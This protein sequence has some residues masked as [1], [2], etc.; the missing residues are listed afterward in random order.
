[1]DSS[2]SRTP[3]AVIWLVFIAGLFYLLSGLALLALPQWFYANVGTFPP[4]NRHYAG[5]LGAFL[6]PIGI[7]LLLAARDPR[8]HR[9]LIGVVAAGNILH[10]LNHLFD[11]ILGQESLAHWL[12]DTVPL[13]LFGA[14][15]LWVFWG[16]IK[17]ISTT[18]A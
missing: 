11:A 6:L 15:F 7:G 9:L 14:L 18:Q 1:M 4:F 2:L 13:V 17:E 10:A 8:R 12:Q 16:Y 3:T 5:D